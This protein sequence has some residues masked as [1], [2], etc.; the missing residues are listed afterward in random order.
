M[1]EFYNID[2]VNGKTRKNLRSV[3]HVNKEIVAK[4]IVCPGDDL[5]MGTRAKHIWCLGRS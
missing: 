5:V 3:E 2:D 4:F 1:H